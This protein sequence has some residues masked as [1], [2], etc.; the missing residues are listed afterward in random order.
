MPLARAPLFTLLLLSA[1]SGDDKTGDSAVDLRAELHFDDGDGD[2][3]ADHIEGSGDSDGD[4]APDAEDTDSD[5][6]CVPDAVELGDVAPGELPYDT[7]Q[8]GLPDFQDPDSDNNGVEDGEEA[9]DCSSPRDGDGDG[10]ADPWDLDDDGDT[11]TDLEEGEDDLDGDG[12]PNR[13]DSDS[14]GDCISDAR[15]AGDEDLSTPAQDTDEDGA[16]DMLDE[17]ADDDGY[18]DSEEAQSCEDPG[19]L[20][21]D[22]VLDPVDPDTDGDGISDA[23]EYAMGTEPRDTDTDDDGLSDLVEEVAGSDPTDPMDTADV[24]VVEVEERHTTEIVIPYELEF[25]GGDIAL[26]VDTTTSM[27]SRL[28]QVREDISM[29]TYNLLA[30]RPHSTL[31]AARF[32]EYATPPMSTGNDVPFFLEQQMTEDLEGAVTAIEGISIDYSAGNYD[33]PEAG[34]EGLYQALT[35]AGYDLDCDGVFDESED[36]LPFKSTG[37]DPFDGDGGQGY[38]PADTSTG[39]IGG[40]GFHERSK[41]IIFVVTDNYM[42]DPDLGEAAGG[43]CPSD[44]GSSDVIEA[45]AAIDATF[46]GLAI[47]HTGSR[48]RMEDLAVAMGST[49]DVDGDGAEDP[50]AFDYTPGDTDLLNTLSAVLE[51]LTADLI[52]IDKLWPEVADDEHGFVISVSP[53]YENLA[54]TYSSGDTVD[55]F[56]EVWGAVPAQQ[57]AQAWPVEIDILTPDGVLD[58]LTIIVSVP[59]R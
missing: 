28:A 50:L 41:P 20:D 58:T 2:G 55:I 52:D 49:A 27:G 51:E 53:T 1:C 43:G 4:G 44:A 31:G 6:D 24:T 21:E 13:R 46:I 26:L 25:P 19:D 32:Q 5:G 22:G 35:G 18:D 7:D 48:E 40:M 9:G 11:V 38:D 33:F 47:A 14:D 57:E 23:D 59:G 30:T 34:Y 12:I 3:I 37:G 56:V 15:E 42:R 36:V 8:D 29:L 17:D 45:A 16:P 39:D 54:E 10:R